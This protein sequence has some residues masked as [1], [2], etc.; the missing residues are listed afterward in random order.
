MLKS[1]KKCMNNSPCCEKPHHPTRLDAKARAPAGKVVI[2][3]MLDWEK[4]RPN[5]EMKKKHA[6]LGLLPKSVFQH[7]PPPPSTAVARVARTDAAAGLVT[8]APLVHKR[9]AC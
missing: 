4:Q 8:N 3:V 1:A 7:R 2:D 5:L 6:Q 9:A